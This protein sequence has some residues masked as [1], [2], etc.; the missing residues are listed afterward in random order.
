MA[1]IDMRLADITNK[2]GGLIG[3]MDNR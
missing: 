1:H 2:L 3:Y